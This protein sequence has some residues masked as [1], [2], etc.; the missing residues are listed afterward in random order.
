MLNTSCSALFTEP[1]I[2]YAARSLKEIAL[3]PYNTCT[4][5]KNQKN[6]KLR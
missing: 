4:A 1:T 3:W 6:G 2:N 5:I